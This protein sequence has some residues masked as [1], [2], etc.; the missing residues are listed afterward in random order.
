MKRFC[1]LLLVSVL[2]TLIVA[3]VS[4]TVNSSPTPAL[5]PDSQQAQWPMPPPRKV[6]SAEKDL[7]ADG[8]SI[9]PPPPKS[10]LTRS[11]LAA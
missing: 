9:P 11:G 1:L 10:K 5:N 8:W 3:P 2:V 6:R 7:I 4:P